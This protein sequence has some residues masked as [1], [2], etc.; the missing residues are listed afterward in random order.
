M[1]IAGSCAVVFLFVCWLCMDLTSR[2]QVVVI[3]YLCRAHELI[4]SVQGQLQKAEASGT[5][6]GEPCTARADPCFPTVLCSEKGELES[7]LTP[8]NNNT[9]EFT[10]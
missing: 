10:D 7:P 9:E 3:H 1:G 2:Q 6:T 4:C 5:R 8:A